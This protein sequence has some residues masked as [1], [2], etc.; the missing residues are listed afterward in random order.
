MSLKEAF[1]RLAVVEQK[2]TAAHERLDKHEEQTSN[3]LKEISQEIK[4]LAAFMH[5]SRGIAMA[6]VSVATLL[7]TILG[8]ILATVIPL[9]FKP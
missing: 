4:E 8:S 3:A 5:R 1:E 6:L 2:A 9:L 7:G